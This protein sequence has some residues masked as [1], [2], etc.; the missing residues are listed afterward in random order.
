M[1]LQSLHE[2]SGPDFSEYKAKLPADMYAK[3]EEMIDLYTKGF[4]FVKSVKRDG[5]DIL[6]HHFTNGLLDLMLHLG[7]S[8]SKKVDTNG[9]NY[10]ILSSVR[11]SIN[12]KYIIPPVGKDSDDA[13]ALALFNE[14][15]HDSSDISAMT[16][17]GKNMQSTISQFTD[18][19]FEMSGELGNIKIKPTNYNI[20]EGYHKG[21]ENRFVAYAGDFVTDRDCSTDKT[22]QRIFK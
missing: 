22:E 14:F 11:C 4:K 5:S 13:H 20:I 1:R 8:E 21:G 6:D 16:L 10:Y 19:Y 12:P 18:W 17:M 9:T 3:F 2:S 15:L 7:I